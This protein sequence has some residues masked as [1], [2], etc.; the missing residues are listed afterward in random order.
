[1][2]L[3]VAD[4]IKMVAN[5]ELTTFDEE[6][7]N[8]V[9]DIRTEYTAELAGLYDFLEKVCYGRKGGGEED[10]EYRDKRESQFSHRLFFV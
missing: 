8:I 9:M 1:M 3:G 10:M 7:N 5:P 6:T 4:I 2:L